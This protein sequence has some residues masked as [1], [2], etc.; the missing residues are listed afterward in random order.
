MNA[1][2]WW[3]NLL[4]LKRFATSGTF[5]PLT[6]HKENLV[7]ALSFSIR[8]ETYLRPLNEST[9]IHWPFKKEIYIYWS[10]HI[11][12]NT[13]VDCF[14]KLVLNQFLITTIQN[15][16]VVRVQETSNVI[17]VPMSFFFFF[18]SVCIVHP[19]QPKVYFT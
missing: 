17:H 7:L 19:T 8:R 4:K 2:S 18:F 14:R 11:Y 5:I 9:C 6:S 12:L 3:T 1:K 10:V 15:I 13:T 16:K